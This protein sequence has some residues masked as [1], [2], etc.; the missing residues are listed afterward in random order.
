MN[1]ISIL[2]KRITSRLFQFIAAIRNYIAV[3]AFCFLLPA[4]SLAAET[5][6]ALRVLPGYYFP[7]NDPLFKPGFGAAAVFD[8]L[9]F[10]YLTIFA[11]GEYVNIGLENVAS[12]SLSDASVGAGYIKKLNDR[13]SLQTDLLAGIYS[14]T[15]K[16]ES[17]S[18][19]SAGAR[20]SGIYNLSPAFSTSINTA[21]RHFAY[22][23]EPFIKSVSISIGLSMNLKEAFNPEKHITATTET[24]DPVFPVLYSWYDDN[25]FSIVLVTNNEKNTITDVKTYFFLE[26]YMGQPKL[27]STI[28]SLVPGESYSVQTTAFFNETMLE[29]SETITTRAKIIVEYKRL[30][31]SRKAE[32]PVSLPVY[33][34]NA[35][36]WQDDRRAA[37]FVSSK[38]PAALWFSKYVSGIVNKRYRHG[39][40]RNIQY[41]MGAFESLDI[42][43]INYVVD[44][45]SA[46]EDNVDDSTSI[47]FLQYPYQTLMYRGGDCDDLSILY[48][49][50]LEAVGIDTAFITIPGHIFMAFST[51]MTEEE[52]K[53]NFY[54]P[55]LLIY[56][57]GTAW[58]PVEATLTKEGFDKAWRIGAKQWN[59]ANPR[60]AAE[61]F[62]M[63][64]SWKIYKP[65]S[66]PGA[67]SRFNLPDESA[68]AIA[69]DKSMDTYIERK[70]RPQIE[71]YNR[72]LAIED[73]AETRN[74]F[75]VL[76]GKYGM[77][78]QAENEFKIAAMRNNIDA[79]TNRGNVQFLAQNYQEALKYYGYVL[80]RDKDNTIAMLGAARC[81]YELDDYGKS[82][83]LYAELAKKDPSLA[84]KYS[85]LGSFFETQGRAWSLSERLATTTWSLPVTKNGIITDSETA[86]TE[87]TS[88]K[89]AVAE[90]EQADGSSTEKDEFS[91]GLSSMLSVTGKPDSAG[92][93]DISAVIAETAKQSVENENLPGS[94]GEPEIT[95]EAELLDEVYLS[96]DTEPETGAGS[97]EDALSLTETVPDQ[98]FMEEPA[99]EIALKETTGTRGSKIEIEETIEEAVEKI[100][101]EE[102]IKPAK[103]KEILPTAAAAAY[104]VEPTE[105]VPEEAPGTDEYEVAAPEAD[106]KKREPESTTET[107]RET[108]IDSETAGRKMFPAL[109][110]SMAAMLASA[111]AAVFIFRK[112]RK[113]RGRNKK[114]APDKREKQNHNN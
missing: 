42:Y 64:E 59:D 23:P 45:T 87:D 2:K 37:A 41:A 80:A 98:D 103:Q 62:P 94:T 12:I 1:N 75:G 102:E 14:V 44:P 8:F 39:I 5:S 21:Y 91:K 83:T 78:R 29:L 70:I 95:E 20:I 35:M 27:C 84:V 17:L 111:A 110:S 18:G 76:Y 10:P 50:L 25:H 38:D 16:E 61:I 51:G 4:G 72:L 32:I 114:P 57:N 6:A 36:S 106:I 19:I 26:Q 43:G 30:G 24:I 52:A 58:V 108:D 85:Y 97:L 88:E 68:V 74:S 89:K 79:W 9:P 77:L 54:A 73:S 86:E 69:F 47:D 96:A 3:F 33:H 112:I 101:A 109:V 104:P 11:Q 67:V 56:H 113:K 55:E 92:I 53:E 63:K 81:Y 100:P 15:R 65:V 22:T 99:E 40:N 34:R 107:D 46:Y 49:S 66:I 31:A 48:C 105:P 7:L 82:D 60:G 93:K 71:A 90:G 13:F 28:P